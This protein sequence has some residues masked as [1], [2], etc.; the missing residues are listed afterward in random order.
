[1]NTG[2]SSKKESASNRLIGHR[3]SKNESHF[4]GVNPRSAKS[5]TQYKAVTGVSC[6]HFVQDRR[7]RSSCAVVESAAIADPESFQ[8][9][10]DPGP[11][12]RGRILRAAFREGK[13]F[14]ARQVT[15]T[16][17]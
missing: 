2:P 9:P 7:M 11:E 3:A 13:G 8:V 5:W 10:S 6:L 4:L 14:V 17:K 12:E 16:L 1:M 15:T